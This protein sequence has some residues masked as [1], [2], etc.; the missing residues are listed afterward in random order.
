[1]EKKRF[2][3]Y[4]EE[5]EISQLKKEAKKEKLSVNS[6]VKNRMLSDAQRYP[7]LATGNWWDSPTILNKLLEQAKAKK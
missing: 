4:L 7:N 6:L 3:L 1:M 5:D 2:N